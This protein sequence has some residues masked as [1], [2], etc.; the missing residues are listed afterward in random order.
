LDGAGFFPQNDGAEAL[1]RSPSEHQSVPIKRRKEI[2]MDALTDRRGVPKYPAQDG[3]VCFGME[4]N[5]D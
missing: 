5:A 1:Q 4:S 2:E 3:F